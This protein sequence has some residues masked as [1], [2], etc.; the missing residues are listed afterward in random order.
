MLSSCGSMNILDWKFDRWIHLEK[1]RQHYQV[2][3][4]P[5]NPPFYDTTMLASF[6]LTQQRDWSTTYILS[7]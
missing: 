1:G 5:R 6:I 3:F 2:A 4:Q 7:A